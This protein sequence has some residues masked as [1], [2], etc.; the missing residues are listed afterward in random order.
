MI[1][2]PADGIYELDQYITFPSVPVT[3]SLTFYA[4]ANNPSCY[5]YTAFGIVGGNYYAQNQFS[6]TGSYQRFRI[7]GTT[8]GNTNR[9]FVALVAQCSGGT[10]N[11]VW[12]DG[13]SLG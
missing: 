13:I 4:F 6:M 7:S 1:S 5:I 12:I 8:D 11:S 9:G 2:F 3:L 10:N